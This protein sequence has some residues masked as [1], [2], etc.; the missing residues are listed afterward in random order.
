MDCYFAP[1]EGITDEIFRSAHH[2]IYPGMEK[3][4]TPFIAPNQNHKF[5]PRDIR[6]VLP[7]NNKGLMLVPQIL[8]NQA[9]QFVYTAEKLSQYGYQEVNLNL[10]CPSQT[11]AAKGKGA[12]QLAD[13]EKLNMFLEEIFRKC[14]IDISIKTRL[15]IEQTEEIFDLVEVYN[16]YPVKELIIHPR[17]KN[18]H[19]KNHPHMDAFYNA[20]K[21]CKSSVCYNGDIVCIADMEKVAGLFPQISKVMIGRGL[22]RN[23]GMCCSITTDAIDFKK[24]RQFHDLLLDG[25]CELLSG[26]TNVLYKMKEIWSYMITV[27]TGQLTYVK[28]IQ[29]VDTL[30]AYRAV[31]SLLFQ[32]ENVVM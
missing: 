4:F 29:K 7:E 22:V 21:K 5:K 10:G 26:E 14:P 20:A 18:E 27:F 32:E 6:G 17:V 16:Q 13:T 25:Y 2:T 28:K 24:L 31:I 30:A 8:T 12:G 3:Y 9:E 1:L 11:V 15:G 19:Y 23:P